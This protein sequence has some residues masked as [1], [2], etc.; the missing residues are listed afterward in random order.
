MTSLKSLVTKT[1]KITDLINKDDVIP[2]KQRQPFLLSKSISYCVKNDR[3]HIHFFWF[4][5]VTKVIR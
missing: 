1:D 4:L 5:K 2:H 3:V